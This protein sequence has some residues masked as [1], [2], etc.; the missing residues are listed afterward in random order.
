MTEL[1]QTV[2]DR[3]QIRKT[4]KQ[5]TA[6]IALLRAHFPDLQIQEGGFPKSR[7]LIIGDVENAKLLLSAHYDTC[8]RLLLPNTVMPKSPLLSFLYGL[9]LVVPML[10]AVFAVSLLISLFTT[11]FLIHYIVCLALLFA[12]LYLM[13]AGPANKHNANDNTSG[14][15]TLCEL[16]VALTPEQRKK[17]AFI[18]FDNEELGLLGS[19]LFRAKY[20]KQLDRKLLI[21]FDCVSD[22]DHIMIAAGRSARK[23]YAAALHRAFRPIDGKV[24]VFTRLERV[25]YHAHFPN[26]VAV[27]AMQHRLFPGYYISRIHTE[28]D[29]VFD[30][31]NIKL[32]CDGVLRLLKSIQEVS[33]GTDAA[34]IL[35]DSG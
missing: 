15:I 34:E 19:S 21:N 11:S 14:V 16:L 10:A 33:H 26:A 7:N 9:L 13:L 2:L 35:Q 25:Y 32:L 27:A 28:K 1:S 23:A 18:F 4:K 30:R 6:F 20:K 12:L 22:G 3:Y 5:K 8:A 29:T 31:K 24:I 17:A